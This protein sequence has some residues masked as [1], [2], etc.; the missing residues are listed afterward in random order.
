[1]VHFKIDHLPSSPNGRQVASRE[2][3]RA[4]SP[5]RRVVIDGTFHALTGTYRIAIKNLSCTG[6]LIQ[7]D[8]P[9]KVGKEGVLEGK[10]VDQFCRIVWTDG[11]LYGLQFD[12]PLN[13]EVVLELHRITGEQV[14]RA[15]TKEAEEWWRTHA[16]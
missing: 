14:D 10:N 8:Q 5:R 6:A 4:R 13:M 9:L 2:A 15:A 3:A 7:C 1:M 12:T 11:R 16:P